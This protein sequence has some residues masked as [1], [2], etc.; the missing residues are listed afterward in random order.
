MGHRLDALTRFSSGGMHYIF[1]S[2]TPHALFENSFTAGWTFS[3]TF[4]TH[5]LNAP[6]SW[7]PGDTRSRKHAG[8]DF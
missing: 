2:T 8:T 3:L 7:V 1:T 4:W 6:S 5:P